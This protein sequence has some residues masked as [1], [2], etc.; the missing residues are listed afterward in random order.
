MSRSARER[1]RAVPGPTTSARARHRPARLRGL[2]CIV[3]LVAVACLP[4]GSRSF[5]SSSGGGGGGGG[6]A[7]PGSTAGATTA[8]V[9]ASTGPGASASFV[10]PTPTPGPTSVVYTVKT[11][12]SLDSIAHHFGTTGRSIAYWNAATYP[13]L[14]PESDQYQPGLLKVGWTL[15]IIPNVTFDEQNLPEPSDLVDDSSA[16]PDASTDEGG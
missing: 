4:A 16:S 1:A 15:Q 10:R 11:G 8:S 2:V 5:G 7:G 13:S 14:D 6:V 3:G 12:D 9:P